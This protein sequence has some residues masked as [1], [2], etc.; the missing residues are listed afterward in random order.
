MLYLIGIC[1]LIRPSHQQFGSIFGAP[2]V[3]PEEPGSKDSFQIDTHC[4]VI[5]SNQ[6]K[7]LEGNK[8]KTHFSGLMSM[9]LT[10][11]F[12]SHSRVSFIHME[13]FVSSKL[14]ISSISYCPYHMAHIIWVIIYGT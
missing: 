2:K 8:M 3:L 4:S 13:K 5:L 1:I 12:K 7:A 6:S 10:S 9:Q 14:I 11:D